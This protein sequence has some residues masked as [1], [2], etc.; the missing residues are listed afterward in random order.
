M[1]CADNSSI[2]FWW[3]ILETKIL[4]FKYSN[5]TAYKHLHIATQILAYF[6]FNIPKYIWE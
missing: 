2:D 5:K 3:I 1:I 6:S 4:I